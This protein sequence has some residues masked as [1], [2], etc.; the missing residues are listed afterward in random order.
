M[1]SNDGG[2]SRQ[3]PHRSA[4]VSSN[5]ILYMTFIRLA[6]IFELLP[7]EISSLLH[8]ASV[9]ST[10]VRTRETSRYLHVAASF[11]DL[12]S[13]FSQ[14]YD[15]SSSPP[16]PLVWAAYLAL[17]KCMSPIPDYWCRVLW[18][19]CLLFVDFMIGRTME[20]MSLFII[21]AERGDGEEKLQTNM[22]AAIQPPRGHLFQIT[23]ALTDA[24]T[25]TLLSTEHVPVLAAQLYY[26]SPVTFLASGL[27]DSFQN[28]W[29]LLLLW[30]IHEVMLTSKKAISLTALS[31]ALATY[32]QPWYIA[33][34]VPIMILQPSRTKAGVFWLLSLLFI[35]WLQGLSFLLVGTKAY[36][37]WKPT[38]QLTPNLGPLWYFQMQLFDRFHDFFHIMVTGLP[39]LTVAPLTIRL[40][41]YPIALVSHFYLCMTATTD[42]SLP[43]LII[44]LFV[45]TDYL[46]MVYWDAL[47]QKSHS[48]RFQC[49]SLFDDNV[50]PLLGSNEYCVVYCTFVHCGPSLS[51]YP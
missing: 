2:V 33:F 31:I 22:P 32:G 8:L 37:T 45:P 48:L 30:S 10:V 36:W 18:R 26:A 42:L 7:E 16:L 25:M 29:F 12:F 23:S 15:A 44:L 14:A 38:L 5:V 9:R 39:Y 46:S 41:R 34:C 27:Y 17:Q 35:L 4:F 51:L 50:A 11:R 49:C 20:R 40:H 13:T 19:L 24:E 28:V 3:L 6:L 1:L 47:S 43:H 21:E